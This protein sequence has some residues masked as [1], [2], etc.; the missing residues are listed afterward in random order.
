MQS[1]E[2]AAPAAGIDNIESP[3]NNE[4][5]EKRAILRERFLKLV[6]FLNENPH[7]AD[8]HLHTDLNMRADILACSPDGQHFIVKNFETPIF[9]LDHAIL[10]TSDI[11]S[12]KL[13][14]E[15]SS[16]DNNN[17]TKK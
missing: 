4:E 11:I 2:I 10:R 8:I 3:V 5:Q 14:L 15:S 12:M 1:D 13:N 9:R 17:N 7:R 16:N 6:K